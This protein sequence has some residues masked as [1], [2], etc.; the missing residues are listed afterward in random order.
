MRAFQA[1]DEDFD[2]AAAGFVTVETGGEDAGV[3]KNE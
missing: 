1:F 2:F 3:V